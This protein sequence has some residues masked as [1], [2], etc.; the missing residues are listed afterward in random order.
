MEQPTIM[1]QVYDKGEQVTGNFYVIDLGD[2][3][4]RMAENDILNCRLTLDTEFQARLN[5]AGSYEIIRI[6]KE[7]PYI[8]RRFLLNS[9][10]TA[11]EY[12]LL[13]DEIV[14]QGGFWQVDFGGIA[15]INLPPACDL[16][17]DDLFKLFGFFP[18]EIV[19][20]NR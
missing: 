1:I 11:V 4:F 5:E 8:T 7:S 10:F 17:L 18:T 15:T 12:R 6:L 13:G 14:R 19:S 20:D 9:Q 3:Q 2:N 16:A